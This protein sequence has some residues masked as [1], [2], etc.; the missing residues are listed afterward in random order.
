MYRTSRWNKFRHYVL[1]NRPLCENCL[2]QNITTGHELELHHVL[3]ATI[4]PDLFYD[5]KNIE[6]LCKKCHSQKTIKGE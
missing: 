2:S 5:E 6:V 1:S 3:K 4:R